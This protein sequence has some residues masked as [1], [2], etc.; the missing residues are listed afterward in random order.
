MRDD[1]GCL[2]IALEDISVTRQAFNTFLNTRAARIIKANHR[3]ADLHRLIHDLGDLARMCTRKCAAE[4]S[5]IL[6]ENKDQTAIDRA[7]TGDD[8]ISGNAVFGH[9]EI[10]T[11]MFDKHV[12]FFEGAFVKQ[13][14]KA[15]TRGELAFLVLIINAA[16]ATAH[17]SFGALRFEFGDNILHV[18]FSLL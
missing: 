9:A 15:F 14:I 13:H 7:V 11:I 17:G 18:A 4:H 10:H 3:C 12:P 2:D 16:L 6:R 8:T 1:A 5:K